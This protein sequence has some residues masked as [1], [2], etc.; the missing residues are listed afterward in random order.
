MA[1]KVGDKHVH[2]VHAH[3]SAKPKRI[4]DHRPCTH[5]GSSVAIV[6]AAFGRIGGAAPLA[7]LSKR[8]MS[9]A[10]LAGSVDRSS[11]VQVAM[12]LGLGLLIAGTSSCILQYYYFFNQLIYHYVLQIDQHKIKAA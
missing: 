3:A 1:D 9:T 12:H 8:T 5:T 6:R 2:R 7:S 11:T 10:G 4:I